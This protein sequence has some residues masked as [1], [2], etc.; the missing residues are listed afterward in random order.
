MNKSSKSNLKDSFRSIAYH[1]LVRQIWWILQSRSKSVNQLKICYI[2]FVLTVCMLCSFSSFVS[3]NKKLNFKDRF[4]YY[5]CFGNL[6]KHKN[7]LSYYQSPY[8]ATEKL[9]IWEEIFITFEDSLKYSLLES[10]VIRFPLSSISLAFVVRPNHIRFG[11]RPW[12]MT[13]LLW[14]ECEDNV[15]S[16]DVE[17]FV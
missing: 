5:S 1:P 7:N 8:T 15:H 11:D 2:C 4:F 17:R 13:Q 14:C 6:Y 12:V 9:T 10:T 3:V 16:G